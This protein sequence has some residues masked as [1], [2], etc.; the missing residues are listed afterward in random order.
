M[1]VIATTAETHT[2]GI[3]GLVRL[4]RAWT[5]RS[6]RAGFFL[7]LYGAREGAEA[8]GGGYGRLL[9]DVRCERRDVTAFITTAQAEQVWLNLKGYAGRIAAR[10][11]DMRARQARIFFWARDLVQRPCGLFSLWKAGRFFLISCATGPAPKVGCGLFFTL[12]TKEQ[13]GGARR[14]DRVMSGL[15]TYPPKGRGRLVMAADRR[16]DWAGPL[17]I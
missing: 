17:L 10:P 11:L 8:E 13:T 1:C 9:A 12:Q 4:R 7:C 14:E 6:A 2:A 3:W 5:G 16:W 15:W